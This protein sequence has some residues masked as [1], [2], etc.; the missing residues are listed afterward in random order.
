MATCSES[1]RRSP[2]LSRTTQ[3][4]EIPSIL[5]RTAASLSSVSKTSSSSPRSNMRWRAAPG[6]TSTSTFTSGTGRMRVTIPYARAHSLS[7]R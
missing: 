3:S 4:S 2:R 6:S 7:G 5:L 1:S